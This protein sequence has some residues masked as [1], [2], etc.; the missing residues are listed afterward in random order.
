MAKPQLTIDG[1]FGESGGQVL[2]FVARIVA[3]DRQTVR[4]R[5]MPLAIGAHQGTG[6]GFFRTMAF[7]RHATT[8]LQILRQFLDVKIAIET[9]SR[10]NS[11]VRIDSSP[12]T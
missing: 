1:S 4:H 12:T 6:G 9:N 11:I 5:E 2:L 8:N 10:N 3:R 7:S